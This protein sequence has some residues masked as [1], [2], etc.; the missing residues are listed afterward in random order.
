MVEKGTVGGPSS[1]AASARG[2]TAVEQG[3]SPWA[4]TIEEELRGE[5]DE[6]SNRVRAR[7]RRHRSVGGEGLDAADAQLFPQEI[8][9]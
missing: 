9:S 1:L 2:R 4:M 8:A 3:A 5:A 7:G 6:G